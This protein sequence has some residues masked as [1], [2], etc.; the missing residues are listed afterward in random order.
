MDVYV[1][2][3]SQ[4]EQIH[5]YTMNRYTYPRYMQYGNYFCEITLVKGYFVGNIYTDVTNGRTYY[6]TSMYRLLYYIVR[7][8][9][10]TSDLATCLAD[11]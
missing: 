2:K 9:I 1:K 10:I 7:C 4:N 8:F 6:D 5:I 3:N 11:I